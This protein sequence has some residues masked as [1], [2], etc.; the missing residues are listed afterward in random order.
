MGA[1]NPHRLTAL[2]QQ[3]LIIFETLQCGNNSVQGFV[4]ACSL[5]GSAIHDQIIG[6]FS[7]IRVQ[8]IH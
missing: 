3:G 6:F 4:V 8:V 7:H 2:D 1:K 5:A